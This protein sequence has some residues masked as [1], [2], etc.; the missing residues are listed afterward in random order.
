VIRDLAVCSSNSSNLSTREKYAWRGVCYII[1][2]DDDYMI[3]VELEMIKSVV[4]SIIDL[5]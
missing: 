1:I 3:I 5:S 2:N 4:F